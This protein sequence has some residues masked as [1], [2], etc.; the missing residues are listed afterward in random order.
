MRRSP[1][2]PI[3][4]VGETAA[5]VE[6][7][8]WNHMNGINSAPIVERYGLFLRPDL[9]EHLPSVD[10]RPESKALE[11]ATMDDLER[12]GFTVRGG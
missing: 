12:Q 4:Y 9:Y 8:F 1:E 2:F 5:S 10:T 7:R 6:C 3:V 11:R